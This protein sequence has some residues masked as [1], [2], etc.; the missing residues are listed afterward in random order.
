MRL[1][2]YL[3]TFTMISAA[4]WAQHK[5]MPETLF[6][7]RYVMVLLNNRDSAQFIKAQEMVND[8]DG[9]IIHAFL[10]T[11]IQ[12]YLTRR[13]EEVLCQS[14]LVREIVDSVF[15]GDMTRMSERDRMIVRVWN[16]QFKPLLATR[17][18]EEDGDNDR[19]PREVPGKYQTSEYMMGSVAVGVVFVESDGSLE[20][21]TENW[22]DYSKEDMIFQIRKGLDWWAQQGG[23][24]A[25]LTWNYE[26]K[27]VTTKY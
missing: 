3:I 20:K 25:S 1:R 11:I 6:E 10:P 16:Q 8:N 18:Q 4:A 9:H 12:G 19:T 2:Y 14:G 23:Y 17:G 15:T 21:S 5:T 7:G 26:F 13:G 27:D 24:R 22:D